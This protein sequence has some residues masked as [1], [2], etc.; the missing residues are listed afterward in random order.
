MK[1][2]REIGRYIARY[3]SCENFRSRKIDTARYRERR[4]GAVAQIYLACGSCS[5]H[6]RMNLQASEV[7]KN[8]ICKEGIRKIC[9]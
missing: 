6:E 7:C 2:S 9:K 5:Q 3:A 4:R 8:R 1:S